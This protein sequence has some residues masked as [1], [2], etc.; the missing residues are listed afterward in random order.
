MVEEVAEDRVGQEGGGGQVEAGQAAVVDHL[1]VG[2]RS[3]SYCKPA[4]S[5]VQ[6]TR[7]YLQTGRV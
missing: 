1:L 2:G 6:W 3:Y 4:Y 7:V 5:A